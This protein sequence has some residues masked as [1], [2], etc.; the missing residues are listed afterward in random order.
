[1]V[2]MPQ[3]VWL[4]RHAITTAPNVFNGAESNVPLS[5]RGFQQASAIGNWFRAIQPD[6]VVSSAMLR[7]VQTAEPIAQQCRIPHDVEPALHERRIGRLAGTGFTLTGGPWNETLVQWQAGKTSY[8]TPDAESYD[9]LRDRLLPAWERVMAQHAGKRLVIVAHG[10]VIKV[11]LLS[12]LRHLG[13]TKWAT[14]GKVENVSVTE[15]LPSNDGWCANSLLY[16]PESV[17]RLNTVSAM[18]DA[19]PPLG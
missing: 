2:Q 1:M 4:L 6:A 3:R 14:L 17:R 9:D 13:P 11:L 16:L 15:L 12:L 18:M 7:A 10:I 8:T 5:D 19:A